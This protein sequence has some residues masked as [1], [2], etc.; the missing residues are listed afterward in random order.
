VPIFAESAP[1]VIAANSKKFTH[2]FS[3]IVQQ[4][5]GNDA[6][7]PGGT[8]TDLS[9]RLVRFQVTANLDNPFVTASIVLSLGKG[10]TSLSPLVSTS[11]REGFGPI[12]S[13]GRAIALPV[14]RPHNIVS[15][16]VDIAHTHEPFDLFTGRLDRVS[17][18]GDELTLTCRD[19]GAYIQEASIRET[20]MYGSAGGTLDSV[21]MQ[22]ILTDNGWSQYQLDVAD[23]SDFNLYPYPVGEVGALDALRTIAQQ[24]GRD[25]RWFPTGWRGRPGGGIVHYYDPGRDRILP[26]AVI[27]R[28]RYDRIDTLEW[29]DE[30]VRNDWMIWYRDPD[31][32]LPV[33]P[34]QTVSGSSVAL[35][36]RRKAR[37][38]LDRADNI[39][40]NAGVV[41]FGELVLADSEDPFATHRIRMALYPNVTL[42][43]LH[44]YLAN[45]REYDEDLQFAVVGYQHTW[46]ANQP[47]Q[48]EIARTTIAGRSRPMAAYREYR[49]SVP[50]KVIVTT[51]PPTDDIYA[52]EGTLIFVTASLAA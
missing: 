14:I 48:R 2:D 19:F 20:T 32:G 15:L 9:G 27:G 24:I 29:G 46:A 21:V 36:G 50:P 6:Y 33:G 35:Y 49:T 45:F 28:D 25:V 38:Y 47:G 18:A 34:Y 26:D 39:I 52:P 13:D 16:G 42:N 31:T 23:P 8:V 40:D 1:A 10:P 12:R 11:P 5:G 43:D 30:D 17:I 51:A 22:Q 3:L 37:I 4:Q 41:K 44:L 7:A